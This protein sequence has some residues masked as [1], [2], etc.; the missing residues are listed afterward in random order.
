MRA[1]PDLA[2]NPIPWLREVAF[3]SGTIDLEDVGA[4]VDGTL[5]SADPTAPGVVVH[6]E[7][8]QNSPRRIRLHLGSGANLRGDVKLDGAFV[9]NEVTVVG[10]SGF[11]GWW[12]ATWGPSDYSAFGYF[13]ARKITGQE[14]LRSREGGW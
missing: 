7:M 3:G 13:C 4:Y 8:R 9:D 6:Q 14:R 2:G 11:A 12:H 5:D 10:T 1:V